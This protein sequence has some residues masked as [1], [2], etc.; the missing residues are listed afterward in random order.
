MNARGTRFDH[1]LHQLESVEVAAESGFGIGDEWREPVDVSM[2]VFGVV[3]LV[4]AHQR[5]IDA[6]H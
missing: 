3:D 4:G 6:A 2:I 5:L 1:G